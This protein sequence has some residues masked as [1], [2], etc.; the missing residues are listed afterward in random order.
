MKFKEAGFV[1]TTI[2]LL[3][4]V[5]GLVSC[6]SMDAEGERPTLNVKTYGAVADGATLDTQSFQAAIDACS[7]A[8]GGVVQVPAGQYHTGTI[9]LKSHVELRLEEG[10]ELL[11]SLNLDDYSKEV[12]G[13]IEAPAFDECLIYAEHAEDIAITGKGVINGRG[14]K[15][16]FPEWISQ[17]DN[18]LGD[19]PMLIRF[20]DCKTV[21][22]EGVAL[23]NAASWCTHLVRCDEVVARGVRIDSRLHKNNDGFDL[24]GCNNVL[25]EGCTIFS[26]DDSICPK[27]TT[28]RRCENLT[29]RN[30]RVESHT[31]AFKCGTSSFGGFRNITIE[32]CDFSGCRMGVIKLLSVDGGLLENIRISNIKMENVEGPL[33]IRLGGRGRVYDKPTEQ[34]YGQEVASEG[35]PPG[36]VRNIHIS[37]I[38]ATVTGEARDRN[39]IMI[40]G[41]PGHCVENVVLENIEI[42]FPG[43]GTAANAQRDVAEDI[44]RYPEQFFFGVL[45]SWGAYIRHAKD[46]EFR[47]VKLTTRLPDARQKIVTVDVEGFV[48]D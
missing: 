11:G 18:Q 12:Q 34:V 38:K 42:S 35:N 32:D 24:D 28:E 9:W 8:G 5:A 6:R 17:A 37:N 27:S 22:F 2:L 3:I 21:L 10:A 48:A 45:P 25:I 15:E 47:N 26:G 29:V 36:I 23:K 31:A 30:C 41:I 4:G 20:V 39:G 44:A 14:C 33:F 19:R 46:I 13:A 40:S 43:G 1:G 16:S 7:A